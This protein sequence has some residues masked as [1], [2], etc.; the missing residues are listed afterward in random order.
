MY[1]VISL[2]NLE[3]IFTPV[4]LTYLI[5]RNIFPN[6]QTTHD[7][8]F[9]LFPTFVFNLILFH[10]STVAQV[11]RKGVEFALSTHL[12]HLGHSTN[13][14]ISSYLLLEHLE[15]ALAIFVVSY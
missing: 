14:L 9:R 10:L 1:H 3:E 5:S 13:T 15:N 12:G 8:R 11:I 7:T 2:T 6:S 4:A